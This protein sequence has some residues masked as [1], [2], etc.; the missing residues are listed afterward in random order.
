MQDQAKK[1]VDEYKTLQA[2]LTQPEVI[3]N[4]RLF[5]EKSKALAILQKQFIIAQKFLD[6]TNQLDEAQKIK[7]DPELQELA[8]IEIEDLKKKLDEI[9]AEMKKALVPIDP[10]DQNNA[11]IEIRAAAGGEESSLFANEL[12]RL[13]LRF[14][15]KHNFKTEIFNHHETEAGGTKEVVF[16]IRGNEAFG[17]L[18]FEAG[19]HRVQRIP[20]TEAKGRVHTST[21]TVAVL[22]ELENIAEI[23]INP[24]DLKIDTYR[25]SG[26]G[27]QHVNK[28]ESA[29]RITHIP[30]GLIVA[31]QDGRSQMSN[32]EKAMQ[33]L[34]SKLYQA[35]KE[36]RA[37][38][39]GSA[40]SSQV[41]SG[42][43]AEKIRTYNFP[44]DRVTDHRLGQNF[45]NIPGI[46]DGEI[47]K[48]ITALKEWHAQILMNQ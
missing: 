24:Q 14:C 11:I 2:E 28:T 16:A 45:S 15:E 29:V 43:R 42:E 18:K 44:Q 25:A 9:N 30:S 5:I 27:G 19:V 17:S 7:N 12:L 26:A 8:N 32:K 33:V 31:C 36:K 47:D 23:E 1:I 39:E 13:Y 48:I 3:S 35:E 38:K 34:S 4:Q 22:P 40:R 46:M 21:C 37:Q 10:D 20:E 6:T 41:G